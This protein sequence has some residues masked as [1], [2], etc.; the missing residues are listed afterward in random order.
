MNRL[1]LL[2]AASWMVT[3][4][5]SP[6]SVIAQGTVR[7]TGGGTATFGVDMDGDGD[8]DGCQFGM[9]VDLRDDGSAEGHLLFAMAGKF[10]F[11]GNMFS[12]Q[13]PVTE[14]EVNA[15]GSVTFRGC[16]PMNQIGV[17]K[18][19]TVPCGVPFEVTVGAGGR[20]VGTIQF[21]AIGFFAGGPGDTDL[22]NGNYDQPT[23]TVR[24]GQITVH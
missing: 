12:I 18:I 13:G 8:I 4:T 11:V 3:I 15:D 24:S 9:M 20:G 2:L 5:L 6:S 21:T 10:D 7:V 16:G 14:G 19:Y 23:Q 1:T 17:G 22:T